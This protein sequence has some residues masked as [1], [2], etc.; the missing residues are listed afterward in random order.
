MR[1][2]VQNAHRGGC[3][4]DAMLVRALEV[5]ATAAQ[6]YKSFNAMSVAHERELR[7]YLARR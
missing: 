7:S 2:N 3:I 5:G 6:T 1:S 4:T